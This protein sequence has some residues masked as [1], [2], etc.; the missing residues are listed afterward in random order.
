[1]LE[2]RR[3][4]NNVWEQGVTVESLQLKPTRSHENVDRGQSSNLIF[5]VTPTV[6]HHK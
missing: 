2:G 4:C 1:M 3:A 6:P 5:T